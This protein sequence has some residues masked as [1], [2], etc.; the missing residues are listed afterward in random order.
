MRKWLNGIISVNLFSPQNSLSE[1]HCNNQ[2]LSAV[3]LLLKLAT[4][5]TLHISIRGLVF[6]QFAIS[7]QKNMTQHS[8]AT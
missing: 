1:P 6:D 2:A 3:A 4:K 8:L 7:Q 5:I